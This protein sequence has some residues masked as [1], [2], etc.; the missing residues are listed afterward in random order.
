MKEEIEG[1]KPYVSKGIERVERKRE[2]KGI[3]KRRGGE[4]VQESAVS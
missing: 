3:G 2:K 1:E 4:K